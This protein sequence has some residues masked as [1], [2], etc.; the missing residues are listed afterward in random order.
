[1]FTDIVAYNRAVRLLVVLDKLGINSAR[2]IWRDE[3]DRFVDR[4]EELEVIHRDE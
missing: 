1:V 2:E 4:M 3:I